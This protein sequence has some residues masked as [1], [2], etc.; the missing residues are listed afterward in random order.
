MVLIHI[1]TNSNSNK[2]S[3]SNLTVQQTK[4]FGAGAISFLGF[5]FCVVRVE[6]QACNN[7]SEENT[8]G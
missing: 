3:A 6:M 1:E 2:V 7:L 4:L 5:V 8:W